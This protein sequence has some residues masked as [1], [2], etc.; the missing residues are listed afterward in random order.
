MTEM[1]K[2]VVTVV[3]VLVFAAAAFGL[4]VFFRRVADAGHQL[5]VS[6]EGTTKMGPIGFLHFNS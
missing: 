2:I 6:N 5:F 3:I 4:G 1:D